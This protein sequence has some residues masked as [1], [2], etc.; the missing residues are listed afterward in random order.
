MDRDTVIA[1]LRAHESELRAAG[2][3][4]LALIGSVARDQAGDASDID[5]VVRLS[6]AANR[7][8][9]AYYGRLEAPRRRLAEL[10]GRPVDVIAE[11]VVAPALRQAIAQDSAVVL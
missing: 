9:F 3:D 5:V 1:T 7:G 11:P 6:E 10:L 8:G 4:G 2:V